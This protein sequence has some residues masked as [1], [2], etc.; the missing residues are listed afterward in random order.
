MTTQADAFIRLAKNPL[1]LRLFLFAQVPSTFFAG[2]R[3]KQI[4][5]N[6]CTTTIRYSWLTRNP[7][8][9]IY[10]ACLGMAAEVSTGALGLAHIYKREPGLSMLVT[11]MEGNYYKKAVGTIHF[12][13]EDGISIR[14][15]VE[16]AIST[17]EGQMITARSVGTN[18]AGEPVAEFFITW[19]F[20]TRS[21]K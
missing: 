16:K 12:F 1:K 5:E 8:R 2:L 7:F 4:D 10:F 14:D 6:S 15:T 19:S 3:V 13:C 9:S 20:K 17:G 18:S 21:R 11:K